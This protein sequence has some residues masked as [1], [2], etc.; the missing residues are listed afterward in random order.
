MACSLCIETFKPIGPLKQVPCSNCDFQV[1]TKC[2]EQYQ[3]DKSGL[4][5][6]YCMNCKSPWDRDHLHDHVP[7]AVIKRL[8][9]HTKKRLREEETSLMPETQ[10][11]FEY[12]RAVETKKV[13]EY[14]EYAREYSGLCTQIFEMEIE[15]DRNKNY[16][17]ILADLRIK[18]ERIKR[19]LRYIKN[20]IIWWR[21][22]LRI[23]SRFRDIVPD[24]L[25][26]KLFPNHRNNDPVKDKSH[27]IVLC[28]CPKEDCRGFVTKRSYTCGVCDYKVCD[29]CHQ[30]LS[31]NE[32]VC[33]EDDIKTA[34]F[35]LKTSRACPKCAA[36]IHK[37]EGCDQMWCTHCNT[38]F[39]WRT[40]SILINQTI[41]NP[42]YYDWLRQNPNTNTRQEPIDNCEGL[43]AIAHVSRHIHLVFK[44]RRFTGFVLKVHRECSHFM[45]VTLRR[46]ENGEPNEAENFRKNLDL[47]LK[48]L[49]NK[50]TDKAFDSTVHRRYKA[51]LVIQRIQQVYDLIVTLCSDVFHRLLR[52]NNATSEIVYSYV[53]E[54]DEIFKYANTCFAKLTKVYNVKMPTVR[55][56]VRDQ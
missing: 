6:V 41:H 38:A 36:R 1:C 15:K 53:T 9:V 11:Y 50:L 26:T 4:Y 55:I 51:K 48:W 8:T 18:S 34:E 14:L 40:G 20:E 44:D 35:I 56:P 17:N 46:N 7:A 13:N 16:Q 10:L 24:D 28:P 19:E 30:S 27:A 3:T 2:F 12:D 49:Q 23:S 32:H 25:Y 37:I 54:F 52:E 47:R 42:H 5:E 39:S 45:H 31:E 21:K 43:P 33:S 22:E 29:K